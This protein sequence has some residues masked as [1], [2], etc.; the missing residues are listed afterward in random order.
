M[1]P[2]LATGAALMRS[3]APP[4]DGREA[5]PNDGRAPLG[6]RAQRPPGFRIRA[7]FRQFS[8][9]LA[10]NGLAAAARV[11]A[12]SCPETKASRRVLARALR[13]E[14]APRG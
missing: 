3:S 2:L 13:R 14:E 9:N 6:P 11:S 1:L 7:P 5:P 12:G 8:A 10:P 4:G